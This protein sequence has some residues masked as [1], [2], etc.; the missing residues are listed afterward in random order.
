LWVIEFPL[1]YI[2]SKH[3]GLGSTGLW[4]AAPSAAFITAMISVAYF[5]IG[6]WKDIKLVEDGSDQDLE[7]E[8]LHETMIEEG[9]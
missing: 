6:R 1:T 2:L 5:K 8:I 4:V 3:T 7:Q 9:F